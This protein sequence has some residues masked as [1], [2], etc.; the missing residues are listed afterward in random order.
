M[1]NTGDQQFMSRCCPNIITVLEFCPL[2]CDMSLV[3]DAYFLG[4]LS[5]TSKR[6][7]IPCLLTCIINQI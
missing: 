6:Y 1:T 2:V 5:G 4:A 7:C 3:C